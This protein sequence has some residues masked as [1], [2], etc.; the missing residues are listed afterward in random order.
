MELGYFKQLWELMN[1]F[2][3]VPAYQLLSTII[4]CTSVPAAGV[5]T[6]VTVLYTD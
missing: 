6:V 5:Y 2:S 4:R 1:L 3:T